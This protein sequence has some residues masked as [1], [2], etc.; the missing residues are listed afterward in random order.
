M[1]G[2]R[3]SKAKSAIKT[4]FQEFNSNIAF[5][6]KA[7]CCRAVLLLQPQGRTA[8][9][10]MSAS[11]F[12]WRGTLFAQTAFSRRS[13]GKRR[14]RCH[15]LDKA[16]IVRLSLERLCNDIDREEAEKRRSED[17]SIAKDYVRSRLRR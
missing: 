1:V 17:W 2:S 9:I 4:A 5:R 6:A 16:G 15:A 7:A 3:F 13:T 8:C 11:H 12:D 14:T 10:R